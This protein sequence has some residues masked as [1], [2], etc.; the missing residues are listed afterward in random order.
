MRPTPLVSLVLAASC[1]VAACIHATGQL[2][3][4]PPPEYEET[5][6]PTSASTTLPAGQAEGRSPVALPTNATSGGDAGAL[7]TRPA[8]EPPA[9]H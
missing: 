7:P 2:P 3:G 8:S 9:L 1:A 6:L 5:P 4:G